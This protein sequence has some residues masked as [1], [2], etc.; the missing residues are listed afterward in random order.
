V[1]SSGFAISKLPAPIGPMPQVV[2]LYGKGGDGD[3]TATLKW[4]RIYGANSYLV[5]MSEDGV[6]FNLV[7]TTTRSRDVLITNLVPGTF[8]FFRVA[9]VG[10]AGQGAFSNAYKVLAS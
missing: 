10:A 3:G 4:T 6:V 7:I 1:L 8:Y 2:S 9:A 5:Q